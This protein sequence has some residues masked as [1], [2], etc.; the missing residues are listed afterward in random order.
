MSIIWYIKQVC[1]MHIMGCITISM[2]PVASDW[3]TFNDFTS[4]GIIPHGNIYGSFN[5]HARDFVCIS[6]HSKWQWQ[7]FEIWTWSVAWHVYYW[8]N[9]HFNEAGHQQLGHIHWFLTIMPH[10]NSYGF[11]YMHARDIVCIS[12]DSQW[13]W[14]SFEI[15]TRA[16]VWISRDIWSFQ[17]CI[18][19]AI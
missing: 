17:W 1:S 11:F 12:I 18:S 5:M 10:R 4:P 19:P 9:D 16:V 2:R 13:Q 14:Q 8:M 6:I 7:L 15:K 3:V